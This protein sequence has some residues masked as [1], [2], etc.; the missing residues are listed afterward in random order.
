MFVAVSSL[1]AEPSRTDALEARFLARK[2]LVDQHPGFRR[3]QLLRGRG[4]GE[5]LLVLEWDDLASFK[6]YVQSADFQHAHVALDEGIRAGGLRLYD[7]LL[8]S[9]REA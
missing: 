7:T 6:A 3:L 1:Q 8:D 2:K 5:Y 4:T 9:A